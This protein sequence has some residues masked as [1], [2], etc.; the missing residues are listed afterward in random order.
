[1]CISCLQ[2]Q[3]I[4]IEDYDK[5]LSEYLASVCCPTCALY[6]IFLKHI[7]MRL[8]VVCHA[9]MKK[10]EEICPNKVRRLTLIEKKNKIRNQ[11]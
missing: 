7:N 2:N 5:Y 11:S 9:K 6:P 4:A 3:L 8:K 1:M 10:T